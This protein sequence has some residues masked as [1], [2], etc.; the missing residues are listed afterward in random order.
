MKAR[1]SRGELRGNAFNSAG[2]GRGYGYGRGDG[3]GHGEGFGDGYGSGDG[4][5]YGEG[6][7]TIT[8]PIFEAV[9][10]EATPRK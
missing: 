6:Y 4:Y 3:S 5:G 8:F 10:E 9:N 7:G 2:Y 1:V